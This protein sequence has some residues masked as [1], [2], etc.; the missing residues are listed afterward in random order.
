MEERKHM[1]Y[2]K[3]LLPAVLLILV[4]G[5]AGAL[6]SR[7]KNTAEVIGEESVISADTKTTNLTVCAEP[8]TSADPA[9]A[10]LQAA[11]FAFTDADQNPVRLSD[12][13]GKPIV[14]NFWASWCGPCTSEL[15][16]FEDV[17][18]LYGDKVQFLMVNLTDGYQETLATAASY[19]EKEGFLFPVFFDTT[20]EGAH[21]YGIY[22]IPQTFLIDSKGYLQTQYVGSV[23]EESLVKGIEKLLAAEE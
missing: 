7:L 12:Y 1:K 8:E 18:S 16:A 4:L 23:K 5:G 11:D 15:P 22:S 20:G 9:Y 14:L 6:Y 13:I 17:R 10:P 3:L 19:L 2:G 21:A